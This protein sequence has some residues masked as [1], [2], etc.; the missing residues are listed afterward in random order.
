MIRKKNDNAIYFIISKIMSSKSI[1][2][3]K[4]NINYIFKNKLYEHFKTKCYDKIAVVITAKILSIKNFS[5]ENFNLRLSKLKSFNIIITT[6][7]F[8]R[9]FENFSDSKSFFV[10]IK[11]KKS[12]NKSFKKSSIFFDVLIIRFNVDHNKNIDIDYEFRD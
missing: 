3:R 6:K 1:R 4:Y 8:N 9:K 7:D 2:C 10:D 11:S 5:I 12:F